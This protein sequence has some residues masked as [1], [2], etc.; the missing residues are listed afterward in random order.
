MIRYIKNELKHL[1]MMIIIAIIFCGIGTL[2]TSY[3]TSKDVYYD[4]SV[5]NLNAGDMQDAID[6]VFQHATDYN[7]MNTRVTALENNFLD[8]TYP[9]GSIYIS[10]TD[11]TASA[12]AARFGGT[13]EAYATGRTLIGMGSNGTDNYS[14]IG[15]TGG[16]ATVTL[17]ESNIP[18]HRHTFTP[19]GSVS[20]SFTGTRTTTESAGGHA[21]SFRDFVMTPDTGSTKAAAYGSSSV[22]GGSTSSVG[23]HSHYYTPSGSVSSSFSGNSGN[24]GYYGGDSNG[25]TASFSTIDP[26]ITVYMWKRTA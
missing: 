24:T 15:A 3:V 10:T 13:W 14:T 12:V 23:N 2:A 4:N 17:T 16:S 7:N 5:S 1:P 8:K 25:N 20:S 19:S 6:E 21:H 18:K 11:S 22:V 9:V 26:Y